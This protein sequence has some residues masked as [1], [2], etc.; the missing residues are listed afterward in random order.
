MQTRLLDVRYALRV[1]RANPALFAAAVLSLAIGIG[2]NSVLFSV[3]DAVGFRPLPI[4]EPAS[5][6]SV[7]SST[8][9]G[10][11][12]D[13]L[14][15]EGVTYRD[16]VEIHDRVAAFASVGASARTGFGLSGGAEAAE[17]VTG[18]TVTAS[19]LQTMGVR[20]RLGRAEARRPEV[21]VRVALGAGRWR[22][23][24]QLLTE[25]A[26]LSI[27]G[28]V[29]GALLAW[30]PDVVPL[31]KGATPGAGSRVRHLTP[32]YLLAVGQVAVS[33]ALLVSSAL[34]ARSFLNQR[35][36]DPGFVARASGSFRTGSI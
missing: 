32:Q 4:R 14:D 31:L 15:I 21:A 8:V 34:L 1:F 33:L 16:Y 26:L 22:L 11:E 29:A 5:L 35:S 27:A 3:I 19:Y 36:I 20:A 18:A 17:V 10:P 23:V 13:S 7:R 25:S 28:A 2:P 6:V 30:W 12:S 9:T 24:R